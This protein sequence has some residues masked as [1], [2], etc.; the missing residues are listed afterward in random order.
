MERNLEKRLKLLKQ[1]IFPKWKMPND[2]QGFSPSF[3]QGIHKANDN[4]AQW[5][6]FA[7]ESN[8]FLTGGLY[9]LPVASHVA[10]SKGT[11]DL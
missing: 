1:C 4:N 8:K 5:K 10:S 11:S 7:V 9:A 3:R 6:I 2:S